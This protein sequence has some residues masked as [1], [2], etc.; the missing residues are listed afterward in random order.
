MKLV[1]LVPG[2]PINEKKAVKESMIDYNMK[3]KKHCK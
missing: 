2:Q 1:D 3:P